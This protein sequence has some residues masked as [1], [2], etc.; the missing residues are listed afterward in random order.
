MTSQFFTYNKGKVL[1]A[2][3]YHFITRKEIKGMLIIVNVFA[4]I[5]AILFFLKKI[6]PFAFLSSSI[7]WFMLMIAFWF[8]LPL[9][10]YRGSKTFKERFQATITNDAFTISNERGSQSWEWN[11]F[12]SWMESPHFFHLYFNARTFFIIP[13]DAFAEEEWHDI[14]MVLKENIK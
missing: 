1:Q 4:I 9:I 12:A 11:S 6:N 8:L 14:R 5:S 13:K 7:L 2:L 10:I 3:R